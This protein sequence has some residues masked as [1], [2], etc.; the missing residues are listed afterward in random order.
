MSPILAETKTYYEIFSDVILEVVGIGGH[1]CSES[2]YDAVHF[3]TFSWVCV[4]IP[5]RRE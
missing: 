3:K 5:R 2:G 4:M 1:L